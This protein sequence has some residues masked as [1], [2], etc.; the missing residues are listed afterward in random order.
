MS[1][2]GKQRLISWQT[3][4]SAVAGILLGF[5]CIFKPLASALLLALGAG[6]GAL[7]IWLTVRIINRRERWA[8]R[9]LAALVCLPLLY[10]LSFGP[11]CGLAV[12]FHGPDWILSIYGPLFFIQDH[13]PDWIGSALGANLELCGAF[14]G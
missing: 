7:C 3:V 5:A 8:K 10:V 12:A 2:P 1:E 11:V 9:T 14:A 6:L 13:G 4:A